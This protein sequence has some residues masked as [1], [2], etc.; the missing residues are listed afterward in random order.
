MQ[1]FYCVFIFTFV[2]GVHGLTFAEQRESSATKIILGA[3]DASIDAPNGLL[4]G[5]LEFK[6]SRLGSLA[7][8]LRTP[9]GI[10]NMEN[11]RFHKPYIRMVIRIAD[12]ALELVGIVDDGKIR[13]KWE[14]K[15]AELEGAWRAGRKKSSGREVD[16]APAPPKN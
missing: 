15:G 4:E 11:P 9:E 12:L 13:G 2:L 16:P 10:L 8:T 7:A 6:I 5:N 1:C 3:W 14:F